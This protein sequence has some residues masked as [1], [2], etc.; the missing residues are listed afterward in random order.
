MPH[1]IG[2]DI[3][4]TQLR[5]G[6]VNAEGTG[7]ALV[8]GSS[9]A[10]DNPDRLIEAIVE[11]LETPEIAPYLEAGEITGIGIGMAGLVDCDAGIVYASPHFPKIKRFA[12]KAALDK[13]LTAIGY[14][15][16]IVIDNDANFLALGESGLGAAQAWADFLLIAVGTG[17]G[18]GFIRGNAI[19]HGTTGFAGEVGHVCLNP[20]GPPC[21][22]GSRGCWETVAS[23]SGLRNL[24]T[25]ADPR[26]PLLADY[27]RDI[28]YPLFELAQ[29][30]DRF[31]L[32]IYE[33]LGRNLAIGLGSLVNITG[34][35]RFILAG[36]FYEAQH[37]FM[38]RLEAELPRWTYTSA[39]APTIEIRWSTLAPWGGVFGAACA[40]RTCG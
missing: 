13:A 7:L 16:P 3:G 26:H 30:G 5:I 33:A 37:L 17:I 35:H 28:G 38:P 32:A 10:K 40:A 15:L 20:N 9:F 14:K 25:A 29:T 31:A 6:V 1:T 34:L 2:L 18:G 4:G 21:P 11:T 12:M 24:V 22:C 27:T 19:D 23:G 36:G 39:Y 8:Q